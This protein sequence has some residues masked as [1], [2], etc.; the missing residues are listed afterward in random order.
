MFSFKCKGWTTKSKLFTHCTA[1]SRRF[2][3]KM[4]CQDR[5]R[6]FVRTVSCIIFLTQTGLDV[7]SGPSYGWSLVVTSR[8]GRLWMI[9]GW[10]RVITGNAWA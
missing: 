5:L 1:V 4:F 6:R 8:Y 9:M 7:L 10:S 2:V 3:K